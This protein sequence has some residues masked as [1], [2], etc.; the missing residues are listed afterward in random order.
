ME[1]GAFGCLWG[2]SA[3]SFFEL[4]LPEVVETGTNS[5]GNVAF[6]RIIDELIQLCG[7]IV[8]GKSAEHL[9]AGRDVDTPSDAD[10]S[11]EFHDVPFV[12]GRFSLPLYISIL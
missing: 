10:V 4:P 2:L 12:G 7:S 6:G 3:G 5:R 1:S 9:V 8:G 11:F